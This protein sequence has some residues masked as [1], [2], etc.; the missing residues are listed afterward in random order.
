MRAVYALSYHLPCSKQLAMCCLIHWLT[1]HAVWE[2]SWHVTLPPRILLLCFA[3]WAL[4]QQGLCSHAT[5][6]SPPCESRGLH[7]VSCR[8]S[9]L[10]FLG[11]TTQSSVQGKISP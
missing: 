9:W 5:A 10:P 2:G 8:F 11:K 7:C 1:E 6:L 4:I 3:L